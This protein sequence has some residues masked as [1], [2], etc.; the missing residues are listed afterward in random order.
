MQNTIRWRS[1]QFQPIFEELLFGTHFQTQLIQV[2]RTACTVRV[3][4]FFQIVDV[5]AQR[6]L[7]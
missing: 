6:K 2:W 4:L 5:L 1:D 7:L 3:M